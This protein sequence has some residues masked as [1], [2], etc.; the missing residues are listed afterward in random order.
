MADTNAA[1]D[2][3]RISNDIE[4]DN[5]E[6]ILDFVGAGAS[7][8]DAT[9]VSHLLQPDHASG[10]S[11]MPAKTSRVP[12][13]SKR[14][15]WNSSWIYEICAIVVSVTFMIAIVVVLK[16][17]IHGKLRS[18]WTLPLAPNTVIALFSTLSKSAILL[19]ITAC[20]SQLKWIYFGRNGHRVMD[21][22]IFDDASR[23]PIGAISLIL[24]IRWGATIASFGA[25]LTI[26]ALFQDAF[27]QQIYST[28]TD[29][30]QQQGNVSSLAVT[31]C[32][33]TGTLDSG[34][35]SESWCLIVIGFHL[36]SAAS[37]V[38]SHIRGISASVLSGISVP[39]DP[40]F[41]CPS[42]NCTWNSYETLG[43]CS[44]C[45]D[46]SKK[47]QRNCTL[48]HLNY[49]DYSFEG[50]TLST[51][52][53]TSTRNDTAGG[54]ILNSTVVWQSYDS[55]AIVRIFI[56]RV[57]LDEYA[58]MR[59]IPGNYTDV[60]ESL[61][62]CGL[63]WCLKKYDSAKVNNGVF[64]ESLSTNPPLLQD[65]TGVFE[66]AMANCTENFGFSLTYKVLGGQQLDL[67]SMRLWNIFAKCPDVM[68]ISEEEGLYVVNWNDEKYIK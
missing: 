57:D 38:F 39:Q 53:I 19:V 56:L 45:E 32:Q 68:K 10:E 13:S 2:R 18:S 14:A 35:T 7:G 55:R 9:S 54:T 62:V 51:V 41:N 30:T 15:S 21:L 60:P 61:H 40:S 47:A 36:R 16:T 6:P 44:S 22:Q 46:V 5:T 31:R 29:P 58:Q 24:R 27:Y 59:E 3:R 20:I 12:S 26:L 48:D 50:M 37:S 65:A 43:I 34:Y 4:L 1:R 11:R 17:R 28:Y 8:N 49:C 63:S 25:L 64:E 42:G 67:Q 66:A 52:M 23:G 33:D